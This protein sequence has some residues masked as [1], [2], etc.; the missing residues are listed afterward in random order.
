MALEGGLNALVTNDY[1]LLFL[2]RTKIQVK[3]TVGKL[4]SVVHQQHSTVGGIRTES[5][6]CSCVIF[7][8][9]GAAAFAG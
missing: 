8:W 9:V 1:G 2:S 4:D 7:Q 6:L 3:Y 5:W